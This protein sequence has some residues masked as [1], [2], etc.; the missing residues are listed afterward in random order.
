M[1]MNEFWNNNQCLVPQKGEVGIQLFDN[2]DHFLANC[3]L[4]EV[5]NCTTGTFI[6]F[7]I[8]LRLAGSQTGSTGH[9]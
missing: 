4:R 7:Q 5:F 6:A 1:K 3:I 8:F 9:N 2:S